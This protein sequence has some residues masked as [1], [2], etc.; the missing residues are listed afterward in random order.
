MKS[1]LIIAAVVAAL[2]IPAVSMAAPSR[3]GGY[4]SGFLGA[5]MARDADAT[6]IDYGTLTTY[7]DRIEYDPGIF[8]GGTGGY[9][10]G[11]VR[12][13]GELSYRHAELKS[14]V[15]RDTG[16]SYHNMDGNL[17]ALA[18]MG[19][20]FFDLH[21]DTP[22]TPYFG[23][24][25]GLAVLNLSDTYGISASTGSRD[26]LYSEGDDTVL[27]YQAGAGVEIALN[28]KLSLDV[29][30]RYFGTSKA[31]FDKDISRTT[32]LKLESHN[33]AVGL[34]VKF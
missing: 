26:F 4:V 17:G 28:R 9:D 15:D 19:N 18:M 32:D 24:G 3:P 20:A 27:A 2:S 30:Y 5:S 11:Y 22:V 21:N 1:K 34:R 14:V 6:T 23:G 7:N 10:F 8:V 16:D 12:V 31:T 25:L 13:E 33:V 29:G